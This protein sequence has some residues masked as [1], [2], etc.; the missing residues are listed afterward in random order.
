MLSGLSGV[1]ILGLVLVY[2][3]EIYVFHEIPHRTHIL[4][5][6]WFTIQLETHNIETL[7]ILLLLCR[8]R[9]Q[10]IRLKYKESLYVV[11]F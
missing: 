5:D 9:V 7:G 4:Q 8:D 10:I 1:I 2:A 6:D 11:S 3:N